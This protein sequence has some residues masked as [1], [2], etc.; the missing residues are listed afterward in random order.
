MYAPATSS[1]NQLIKN[2]VQWVAKG[3]S[4]DTVT[5]YTHNGRTVKGLEGN[6]KQTL[7]PEKLATVNPKPDVYYLEGWQHV[8]DAGYKAILDFV[9]NGGGL[10][11]GCDT[12]YLG[13][14]DTRATN[15]NGN[16]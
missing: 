5:I 2:A 12:W 8:S 4:L 3:K 14:D 11:Y 6:T 10:M 9:Q 13:N 15:A 7:A 16:K 1:L